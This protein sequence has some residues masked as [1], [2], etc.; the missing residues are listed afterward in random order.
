MDRPLVYAGALPRDTDILT[1]AKN[2]MVSDGLLAQAFLGTGIV[3]DGF[4]LSP[5]APASLIATLSPGVVFQTANIDAT[6]FGSI[7]ADSRSIVKI[8]KALDATALTF[9]PPSTAGYSQAFL[10]EVQY[11]DV[12][13]GAK[14]L[15][16][17]NAANP[18]QPFAGP[19]NAGTAQNTARR[20]AAA[21]QVK[22]GIAATAGTQQPPSPDAG[23]APLFIVTLNAGQTTITAGNIVQHA[24][25]PFIPTKLPGLPT[26]V[27]SG[28]WVYGVATGTNDLT[29][30]VSPAPAALIDG[31]AV[32]LF[33][34]NTN[35]G[36][37]TLALN[38]NAAAA[39]VT[40]G[41]AALKAGD[42]SGEIIE[43][44]FKS[45]AWRFRT[46]ARSEL[47]QT[48]P[49]LQLVHTGVVAT[50]GAATAT[51][52]VVDVAPNI[53]AY[54]QGALYTITTALASAN[55]GTTANLDGLGTRPVKRF[56]GTP[57]QVGDWLDNAEIILADNGSELRLTNS[58]NGPTVTY[59]NTLKIPGASPKQYITPGSYSLSIPANRTFLV[60]ECRGPG[61]GGGGANAST[62]AGS[63]G[64]GGGNAQKVATA[65]VDTVLT[66][67]VGA[68]GA[69]G[70]GGASPQNGAAGGTTSITVASGSVVD[71]NSTTFNAGQ[72]LCAATS[73]GGG[74][75]STSGANNSQFGAGGIAS[76]GDIND[77]G[78]AGGYGL[79]V[80]PSYLGGVG[81]ASPGAG[82]SPNFNYG[83]AGNTS[84]APGVGGNGSSGNYP[85]GNGSPG[86]VT[87]TV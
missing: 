35:T 23:W 48:V 20:G 21:V 12:D 59:I 45:G 36:A 62:S 9:A 57:I 29:A 83:A 39:V 32:R 22:A 69:G 5:T 74:Y 8:G 1:L 75:F 40:R 33:C 80:G 4:S 58:G 24:S 17:Y 34:P 50:G 73:G 11:Q 72:T 15:P 87:L 78:D 47:A 38:G 53:T 30:S 56:D 77:N 27:Q 64:G 44:V 13:D 41:G 61:G 68:G 65:V 54:E 51:N 25:A 70:A 42:I 46:A 79:P 28:K 16:Y 49:S 66:I 85:G 67:V 31:L 2:A 60:R 82:G 3:V 63:G 14:V 37:V 7:A 84:T 81:G 6:T 55:G 52:L 76:G 10:V 26:A 19:G 18:A 86:R 71:A 43:V